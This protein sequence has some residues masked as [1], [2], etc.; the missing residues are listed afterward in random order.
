MGC[1]PCDLAPDHV[2]GGARDGDDAGEDHEHDH[3]QAP[4]VARLGV[5]VAQHLHTAAATTAAATTTAASRSA[6]QMRRVPSVL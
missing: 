6:D 2:L 5:A 1:I 3:P 4:Q